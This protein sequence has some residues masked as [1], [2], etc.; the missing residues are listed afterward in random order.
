MIRLKIREIAREKKISQSR[1]ARLADVDNGTMRK[2]FRDE[3]ITLET[4]NKIA[5][6]L[7]MHPCNLF[8]YTPDPPP[9]L[10]K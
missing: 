8:D 5:R 7:E 3:N 6:A 9:A 1:L 2:A 4:L 10:E